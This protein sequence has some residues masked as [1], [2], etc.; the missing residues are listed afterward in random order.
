MPRTTGRFGPGV[1][2]GGVFHRSPGNKNVEATGRS[3]VGTQGATTR[4][5]CFSDAFTLIELLVVIAIIAILAGLLLPAL[6]RAREKARQTT[7]TS[8]LRQLG[9]G[10]TL[11]SEDSEQRFPVANFS[12]NTLGFPPS[13]H[14]NAFK[15]VLTPYVPAP[16]VFLC[17]TMRV[18]PGRAGNYPT[19]YKYLCVHGWALL[20]F[21]SGFDNDVCGIC[22]QAVS[23]INRASD[24][25]MVVCDG[26]GEHV[27]LTGDAVFNNGQGGVRGGQNT[28]YVDAHVSLTRGTYQQIVATYQLPNH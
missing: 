12:D 3:A 7:C 23:A 4:T 28:L 8:N 18:Q 20:P 1:V 15:Q 26:L 11:Y 16:G 2:A 25:P 22:G 6:A 27:G 17:P 5:R 10:L 24:K 19:D 21:F 9:L 14:S 13:V